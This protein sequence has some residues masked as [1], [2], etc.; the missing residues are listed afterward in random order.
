MG[1]LNTLP[2]KSAV[3]NFTQI[4]EFA[5]VVF[6]MRFQCSQNISP[7]VSLSY[8]SQFKLPALDSFHRSFNFDDFDPEECLYDLYGVSS[9]SAKGALVRLALRNRILLR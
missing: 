3:V 2:E 6:T 1:G 7:P 4:S 9:P 5:K 8:H